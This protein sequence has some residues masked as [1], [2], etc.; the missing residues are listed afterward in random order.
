MKILNLIMVLSIVSCTNV[1]SADKQ[2]APIKADALEKVLHER[3]P[4]WYAYSTKL[5][6]LKFHLGDGVP[7]MPAK[8][9]TLNDKP[10]I[11]VKDEKDAQ[12]SSVSLMDEDMQP[13]AIEYEPKSA[14]QSGAKKIK[15][16]VVLAGPDA[17]C[18]K[19][20]IILDFT[21][22]QAFVSERFGYNPEDKSCMSFKRAKW[23]ARESYITLAGPMTYVYYTGGKVIGP[24]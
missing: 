10:L 24:I 4:K 23:G 6:T 7:G 21:G 20:F 19:Q 15:R 14:G 2:A 1:Q 13:S 11:N 12:G 17:N 16:M 18:V 8:S 5:G 9:I 22:K 3:D